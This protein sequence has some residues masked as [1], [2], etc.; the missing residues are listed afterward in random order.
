MAIIGAGV[1]SSHPEISEA[2]TDKKVIECKGFPESLDPSQDEYGHGTHAV[3]VI[4][5]T[6]PWVSIYVAR[7]IDENGHLVEDDKYHGTVQVSFILSFF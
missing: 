7:V 2:L 5:R 4:L 1:D 6:M 3:S